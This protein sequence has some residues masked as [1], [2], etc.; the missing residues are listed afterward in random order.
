[1]IDVLK[2]IAGIIF[3]KQ[4]AIFLFFLLLSANFWLMHSIGSNREIPITYTVEYVNLPNNVKITNTLEKE[5]NVSVADA[6]TSFVKYFFVKQTERLVI[7]LKDINRNIKSGRKTYSIDN[8]VKNAVKNDFGKE[9]NISNFAPK[10]IIVEY[11]TLE[12]KKVAV[13]LDSD[14]PVKSQYILSDS[15]GIYPNTVTIY[16]SIQDISMIDTIRINDLSTDS[17]SKS[18]T[19]FYTFKNDKRFSYDPD[20]VKL[21]I[22]IDKSTEKT[23]PIDIEYRNVPDGLTMKAFP[24]KV[25]VSVIVPIGKYNDVDS[26][27]F[28]AEIDYIQRTADNRCPITIVSKSSNIKILR[29]FPQEAEFS[30][31]Y[32]KEK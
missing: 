13:V 32:T 30:L 27:D 7:D 14:I 6:K 29:V 31:E 24:Q 4:T 2:K 8:I 12:N 19:I 10:V 23:I 18:K 21:K 9:A 3:R 11:V 22:S 25:N 16:G 15:V 26:K 1:M 17:L 28:T 20:G 5:I